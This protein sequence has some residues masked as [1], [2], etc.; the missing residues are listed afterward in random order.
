MISLWT[1]FKIW[2]WKWSIIIAS[3]GTYEGDAT[4]ECPDCGA[5]FHYTEYDE[6]EEHHCLIIDK[7]TEVN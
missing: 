4:V 2:C 3:G 6:M 5:I 1:R 7:D